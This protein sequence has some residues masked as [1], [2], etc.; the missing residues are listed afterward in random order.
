MAVPASCQ[1][2]TPWL[3]WKYSSGQI[4]KHDKA[5]DSI[6]HDTDLGKRNVTI[7]NTMKFNEN[8]HISCSQHVFKCI[9]R[10]IGIKV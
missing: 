10:C 5:G 1:N 4:E 2:R 6:W 7:A 9:E 8:C 3:A